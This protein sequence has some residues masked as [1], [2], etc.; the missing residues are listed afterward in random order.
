M[1]KEYKITSP[2]HYE[3]TMIAIF[4]MQEQEEPLTKAQQAEIELMLKAADKYEAEE[5]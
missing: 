1:E 2:K 4:E 5:L 3:E